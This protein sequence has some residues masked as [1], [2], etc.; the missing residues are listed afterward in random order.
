M[1]TEPKGSK[2]SPKAKKT[3]PDWERI[4]LDYRAGIKS[5]REIAADHAVAPSTITRRAKKQG[6]QRDLSER[7]QRKADELV[8]QEEASATRNTERNTPERVL[9][10]SHL[11]PMSEQETVDANAKA[12]AKVKKAHRKDISRAR[13]VAMGLL[14]ELEAMVGIETAKNLAQLGDLL[15]QEDD[16]GRDALNELYQKIISLPGRSK[17]MRELSESMNKLVTMERQAYGMDDKD[18]RP[19][20]SLSTLLDSITQNAGNAFKPVQDDPERLPEPPTSALPMNPDA[21]D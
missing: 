12:V 17:T 6:W 5:L 19:A 2:P 15:R 1:T 4:E 11:P 16:K 18:T 13:K 14:D 9:G 21:E 10:E 8:T 20:D 7:I 3:V